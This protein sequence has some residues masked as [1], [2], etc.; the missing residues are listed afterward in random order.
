[1]ITPMTKT[2]EAELLWSEEELTKKSKMKNEGAGLLLLGIG[3]LAAGV[4][5]HLLFQIMYESRIIW[6]AVTICCVLLGIVLAWFGIK[7]INKVGASVAEETARDSGYTADEI[8]ECYQESRQPSTLLLSLSPSPSKEKDFMEVGFLTKNWLKLPKNIFCG[9]MRISDVAA[10][11]YEE[12]ALPGYDPGIFVVKSDG[13][14]R[15][16]K[17]KSDAGREIVDTITARNSKSITMRCFMFDGNEYDAFQSPQ[18]TA[19]FYRTTQ[20]ER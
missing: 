11:W 14:L 4:C 5:N 7:L 20:Y 9:I 3:I 1:M 6:S 12:T 15:Y 10:I 16:V 8:L 13:K 18:K 17:C 2:L 19:D